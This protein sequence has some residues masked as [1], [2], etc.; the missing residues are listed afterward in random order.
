MI[1]NRCYTAWEMTHLLSSITLSGRL[2]FDGGVYKHFAVSLRGEEGI[3]L[4]RRRASEEGRMARLCEPAARSVGVNISRRRRLLRQYLAPYR[5][6][7]RA[8][9][10]GIAM[11]KIC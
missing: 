9:V 1:K 7:L 11:A 6:E 4:I 5:R 8:S 2:V 10:Y 3:N